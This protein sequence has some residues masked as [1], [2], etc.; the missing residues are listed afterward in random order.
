MFDA[1]C[2]HLFASHEQVP[3]KRMLLRANDFFW[4][5]GLS[6]WYH[7]CEGTCDHSLLLVNCT[8]L[9]ETGEIIC[10]TF[11]CLKKSLEFRS[12][13]NMWRL[14]AIDLCLW[15]LLRETWPCR[16]TER[17]AWPQY[18]YFSQTRSTISR[19]P[20]W[21]GLCIISYGKLNWN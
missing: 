18:L 2:S 15:V 3:E 10:C 19:W 4:L 7:P 6:W 20:M 13:L 11:T 8:K 9:E 14:D 1:Q 21:E 17:D 5:G 12:R 16:Y